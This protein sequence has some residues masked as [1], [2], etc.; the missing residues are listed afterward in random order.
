MV[1]FSTGVVKEF[2]VKRSVPPDAA[3]YHRYVPPGADGVSVAWLPAQIVAPV[4]V[5]ADGVGAA[6]TVAVCDT[7]AQPVVLSDTVTV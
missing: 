5:G 3:S 2:P 4:T 1:A 6:V 7:G